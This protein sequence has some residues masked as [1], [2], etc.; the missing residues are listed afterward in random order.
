M[1]RVKSVRSGRFLLSGWRGFEWVSH[2]LESP[3]SL[4]LPERDGTFEVL[5]SIRKEKRAILIGGSP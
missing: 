2:L 5:P 1:F 3:L 4:K